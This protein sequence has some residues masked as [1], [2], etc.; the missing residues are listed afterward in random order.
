MPSLVNRADFFKSMYAESEG[1]VEFRA[2]ALTGGKPPVR[3]FFHGTDIKGINKFCQE[4]KDT[5]LYFGIGTRDGRAGGKRNIVNFTAV[6][7]DIDFKNTPAEK[8]KGF[9]L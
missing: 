8:E 1:L 6:Y 5:E 7:C 4:N 9:C 2:I 3:S